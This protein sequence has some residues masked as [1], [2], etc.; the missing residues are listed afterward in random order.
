MWHS[1][2]KVRNYTIR[3]CSDY[4]P[5]YLP[6]HARRFDAGFDLRV[7]V[8]GQQQAKCGFRPE[9]AYV[10]GRWCAGAALPTDLSGYVRV[11]A[12]EV[13]IVP[14]GVRWEVTVPEGQQ[15]LVLLLFARSGL[16]GRCRLSLANGVGVVDA[17]YPEEIL[18]ALHNGSAYDHYLSD[19]ARVAQGVLLEA[20]YLGCEVEEVRTS[21]FGHTGV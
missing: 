12:G 17:H 11:G 7:R 4:G 15:T 20:F 16:A 8:A 2:Y 10:D 5:Q 1:E 18:V 14:T 3:F 19:G 9:G 21:G 6:A 13:A